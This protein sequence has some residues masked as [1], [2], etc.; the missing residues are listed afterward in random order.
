LH[1]VDVEAAMALAPGRPD[2]RSLVITGKTAAADGVAV[3]ALA[4]PTGG[5]LPDWAPGAH[6][7]LML[8]GALTDAGWALLYAGRSRTSMAFLDELSGYG[9]RVCL[10]PGDVG[11]RLHLSAWLGAPRPGVKVYCCGPSRLL[12]AV[13]AL[14][15]G[16]PGTRCGPSGSSRRRPL[17]TRATPP[18]RSSCAA[19]AR[20]SR[21]HPASACSTPPGGR[22]RPCS[23][24]ANA[25]RP[26]LARTAFDEAVRLESPVQTFFRTADGDVPIGGAVIPDGKKILMFLS[27]A[28]RDPRRWPDPDAFDLTRDPSGHVGFGM[29]LHQCV[30]QHIARLEGEALLTALARRVESVEL[31]APP[32]RHPDNTLRAL[33]SPPS[34]SGCRGR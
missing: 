17:R 9:D 18:S 30:G 16:W 11:G 29:G 20:R 5:R 27:A 3:L 25:A 19:R 6:L 2:A 26:E 23:P 10:A 33:A 1:F 34:G 28:N 22:A 14:C 7:D 4:R 31:T 15:A 13:A 24:P 21:W 12:D 32:R 8:P